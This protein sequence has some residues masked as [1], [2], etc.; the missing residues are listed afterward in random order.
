[1]E[2]YKLPSGKYASIWYADGFMKV[3]EEQ[4]IIDAYIRDAKRAMENAKTPEQLI[5]ASV[6]RDLSI[7]DIAMVEQAGYT[8]PYAEMVMYIPRKPTNQQYAECDFATY[9]K[10]PNCGAP[11][12]NG[13][14]GIDE[15]CHKCG[16]VLDW[17]E[18][19]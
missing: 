14:G 4:E 7:R 5:E 18:R 15:K 11:V 3:Y 10:C 2:L 19:W 13:M 9:G 8:R 12:R 16:Q 17:K 6:K 1:M